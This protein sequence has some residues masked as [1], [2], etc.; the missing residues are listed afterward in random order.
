MLEIQTVLKNMKEE[1]T[2]MKFTSNDSYYI[3]MII[4][5]YVVGGHLVCVCVCIYG[6]YV[7][8]FH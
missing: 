1:S 6:I 4:F 5:L 8:I 7:Y 2:D 3:L